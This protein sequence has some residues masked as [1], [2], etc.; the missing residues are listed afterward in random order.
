MFDRIHSVDR[1]ELGEM[2]SRRAAALGRV[3]AVQVEVNVSGEATKFGVAA[4]ELA[5][6]ARAMA[7]LPGVKLDGLMTVGAVASESEAARPGFARLRRL[8]D[9]TQQALGMPLP[10]LSMGMSADY[11]V[12]IEEGAT[13]V[14]IGTALFGARESWE[15]ATCS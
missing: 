11:E 5:V 1:L 6:L 3:M 10:E 4:E 8:R 2:I 14:R 15:D 9:E 12:A 13:M 7:R